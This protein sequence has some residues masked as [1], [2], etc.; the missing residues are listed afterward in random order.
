VI[1]L[2]DQPC[3][4]LL[5]SSKAPHAI[6]HYPDSDKV[7]LWSQAGGYQTLLRTEPELDYW[8]GED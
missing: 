6:I 8:D 3:R 2:S 5:L 4:V 1:N 7:G